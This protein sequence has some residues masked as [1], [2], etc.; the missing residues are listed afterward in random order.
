MTRK[1]YVGLKAT[2][3]GSLTSSGTTITFAAGLTHLAGAAVPTLGSGEF[4]PLVIFDSS[5]V[6]QEIVHLTA[7]TSAATT[8]TISRGQEG[9]TGVSHASGDGVKCGPLPEDTRSAGASGTNTAGTSIT[10][11]TSTAMPCATE[12]FDTD[13]FHDTSTNNSRMTIPTGLDGV[14]MV[15]AQLGFTFNNSG[16]VR[17]LTLQLNGSTALG[18]SASGPEIS[19]LSVS[20]I[21]ALAAGDYVEAM[22]Y[23]NSGSAMTLAAAG[24]SL[25]L[26]RLMPTP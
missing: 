8:G 19:N 7:Y 21:V 23:Q 17:G 18:A 15:V 1:A 9:T 12:A 26:Y 13:A 3:G 24:N 2:L 4:I 11:N 22:I 25:S 16:T 14:Y 20:A 5:G 10:N 6:P